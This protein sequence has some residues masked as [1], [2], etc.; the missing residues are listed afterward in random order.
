MDYLHLEIETN[1]QMKIFPIL[2]HFLKSKFS[3]IFLDN[4][5]GTLRFVSQFGFLWHI[6][7]CRLFNVKSI[8]IQINSSILNN[9][10]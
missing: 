6:K 9:L 5:W 1:I 2:F 10:G 7:L 3:T 4:V 8:F